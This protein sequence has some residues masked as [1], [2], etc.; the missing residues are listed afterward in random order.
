MYINDANFAAATII[1]LNK[2]ERQSP[3]KYINFAL[4]KDPSSL[5]AWLN[6]GM[7]SLKQQPPNIEEAV[8]AEKRVKELER[9]EVPLKQAMVDHAYWLVDVVRGEKNRKHGLQVLHSLLG[10]E[11]NSRKIAPN[12][13]HHYTFAKLLARRTKEPHISRDTTVL[14]DLLKK[15]VYQ[16]TVL[17]YSNNPLY[18]IEMWTYL[19]EVQLNES[20]RRLL[21]EEMVKP[22]L[23]SAQCGRYDVKFCVEQ[24]ERYEPETQPRPRNYY[25]RLATFYYHLAK[26]P[27]NPA[28]EQL[29]KK[30]AQAER[31]A[32][33]MG[34]TSRINISVQKDKLKWR[35][36]QKYILY[37]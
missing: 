30:A 17:A 13:S 4:Q 37:S 19:A 20:A 1:P 26:D 35:M 24:M 34:Q 2:I 18:M 6:K 16:L 5:H 32:E 27:T 31:R 8:R 12:L 29:K 22:L 11:R 7:Y 33:E 36:S 28:K 25:K 10:N 14:K 21:T 3:E 9:Q 23:E 15:F